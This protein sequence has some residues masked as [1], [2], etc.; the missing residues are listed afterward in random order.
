M[1]AEAMPTCELQPNANPITHSEP[2]RNIQPHALL[3]R[4]GISEQRACPIS[5]PKGPQSQVWARR[6]S[7]PQ[8]PAA[9]ESMSS[10]PALLGQGELQRVKAQGRG[11]A[12]AQWA[13]E[14]RVLHKVAIVQH[15]VAAGFCLTGSHRAP[16][17][18]T[19]T[20]QGGR[21]TAAPTGANQQQPR[22]AD[23]AQPCSKVPSRARAELK[24]GDWPPPKAVLCTG[25]V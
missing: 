13:D 9:A 18:G 19:G 12:A 6:S 21:P 24:E 16:P 5:F 17:C 23:E 14:V 25:Q 2:A 8:Q 10:P 22:T 1:G 4:E 20:A 3:P 11:A 15:T 7:F